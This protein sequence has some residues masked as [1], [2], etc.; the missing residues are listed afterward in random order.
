MFR[1]SKLILIQ[2]YVAET[3][4]EPKVYKLGGNEWKTR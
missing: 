1:S 4:K 2:K 3:G